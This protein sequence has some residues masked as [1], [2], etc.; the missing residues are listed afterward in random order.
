MSDVVDTKEKKEVKTDIPKSPVASAP[1]A[2]GAPRGRGNEGGS[3]GGS[4]FP[5]R[6]KNVRKGGRPQR[7][8]SEFDQ[9]LINIRRVARV[10]SGGRRFSFSVAMILGNRRGSVGVGTGKGADTAI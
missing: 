10:S 2:Y 6:R 9:K 1:G 4:R 3:G 5:M 8:R 7:A